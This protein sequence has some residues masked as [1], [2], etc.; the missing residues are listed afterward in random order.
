MVKEIIIVDV[1]RHQVCHLKLVSWRDEA[2]SSETPVNVC[3]IRR[4]DPGVGEDVNKSSSWRC[5]M[6]CEHSWHEGLP[7]ERAGMLLACCRLGIWVTTFA[8]I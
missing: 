7:D 1:T 2:D 4:A 3:L 6:L 8:P 5:L